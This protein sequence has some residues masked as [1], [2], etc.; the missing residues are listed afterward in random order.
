MPVN[1]RS[2]REALRTVA[3]PATATLLAMVGSSLAAETAGTLHHSF[4]VTVQRG[5]GAGPVFDDEAAIEETIAAAWSATALGAL[6]AGA[7]VTALHHA[8]D[9]RWYFALDTFATLGAVDAGPEDVVAWNGATH[10][11]VFDGSAAGAP[12]GAAIDALAQAPGFGLI[13]SFDVAVDLGDDV[14]GDEDLVAW[15]GVALSLVFDGSSYGIPEALDLD[16]LDFDGS[17]EELYLSFDGSGE[18]GGV[19]FDDHDLLRFDLAT[20]SKVTYPG[21][22]QAGTDA[23]DLDAA[24]YATVGI[25]SDGFESEGTSRWTL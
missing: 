6:P 1:G 14:A 22:A 4:D 16:A 24:D 9:G 2:L 8:N 10:A 21:L 23:A 18:L 20:W 3:V 5:G 11:L 13:L 12:A 19:D 7:D 25:F 17:T 15:D